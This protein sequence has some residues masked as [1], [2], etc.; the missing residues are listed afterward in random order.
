MASRWGQG[1][2]LT[3]RKAEVA[4]VASNQWQL[5]YFR[6]G[7][8]SNPLSSDGTAAPATAARAVPDG[9]RLVLE[10]ASPHPLTGAITRDWA[11]PNLSP[12]TP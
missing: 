11:R 5:Y 9:V 12:D 8:W 3:A 7:A 2:D 4:L 6:G 10:V 1:G